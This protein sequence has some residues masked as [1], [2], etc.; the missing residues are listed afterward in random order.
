L[1]KSKTKLSP[2]E[3]LNISLSLYFEARKLKK[4]ALKTF[5]PQL[6]DEQL[7]EEVRKIF[8]NAKS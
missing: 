2:A 8:V 6:T 7:E 1:K 3:K 5:Y 4:A